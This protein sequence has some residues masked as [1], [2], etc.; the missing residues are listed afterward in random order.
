[1]TEST[2]PR[3]RRQPEG[4]RLIGYARCSTAA[5]DLIAQQQILLELGVSRDRIYFDKGLTGRNRQRPGLEKALAAVH[6][7]FTLVVPKLDRL[8]HSV[9]DARAIAEE[10]E[11]RGA[12]LQTR[13]DRL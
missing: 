4:G 6:D 9:P 11:Q 8:A 13:S 2:R 10:L 3:Q 12:R 7:G 5:Q 1:M